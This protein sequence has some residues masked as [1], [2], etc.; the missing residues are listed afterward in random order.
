MSTQTL[1]NPYPGL[2]SFEPEDAHLFFG[3]DEQI[4]ELLRRLAQQRF[5]AVVGVSGSGKSSL[6]RAGVIPAL[7]R[8]YLSR[9][10]TRWRIAT[11]RPGNDPF[12]SLDQALRRDVQCEAALTRSSYA[13]IH[14][15]GTLAA[16]E[17]LLVVIDQFEEIFRYQEKLRGASEEIRREAAER[18]ADFVRLLLT[19]AQAA[20]APVYIVI[21]MRSDYLGDCAQFRDLPEALNG[22]QYLIPRMTREQRREAIEGP[23][24]P[25][26]IAPRLV[27][28]VLNDAGDEPVQLPILQHALMRTWERWRKRSKLGDPIDLPHYRAIGGFENALNRHA[29]IAF[30]TLRHDEETRRTIKVVFQRLTEKGANN[31]ETR[32]PTQLKELFAVVGASNEP[33]KQR[34]VVEAINH[35]RAPGAAFLISPDPELKADSVIDITHES[36]IRLW[37]RLRKWV[38]GEAESANVYRRLIES[39]QLYEK[40]KEDLLHGPAL[41]NTLAWKKEQQPT[42]AWAARY[43]GDFDS[44]MAF[45]DAS[46]REEAR[47]LEERERA[48]T[49]ELERAKER[50]RMLVFAVAGVGLAFLVGVLFYYQARQQRAMALSSRDQ[51]EKLIQFMTVD[52]RN[53]LKP[54]GHLDLMDRVNERVRNYYEKMGNAGTPGSQRW[55]AVALDNDGDALLARG[56]L[57]EALVNFQAGN[58]I[59]ERLT[60]QDPGNAGWQQDLC[61][62]YDSVGDVLSAQNKLPEALEAYQASKTIRE[63]LAKQDPSNFGWQWNLSVSYEKLG[64]VLEVQGKLEDALA[65]YQT[66]ET[67]RGRLAK[68][69]P[70]NANIQRDL[71]VSHGNLGAAL[72][73]QGKLDEALAS[74][75]ADKTII[76]RLAKQDPSNAEWQRDLSISFINVG[77]ILQAKGKL[78]EAVAAYEA[79]QTISER[80]VKLEPTNSDWQN[81]FAWVNNRL[82]SI[83]SGRSRK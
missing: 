44:A 31:R 78:D 66:N 34:V 64:R 6:V 50:A 43:G 82:A 28:T 65:A 57:A 1:S 80:L 52:L 13:L 29:E 15:T 83:E 69:D 73:A 38:D 79:S 12:A 5:V 72:Q 37:K 8:G 11:A 36:L 10:R 59:F 22:G 55:R 3:R 60:R 58:T 70:S 40:G 16:D 2:R 77:V 71:S 26:V 32:R 18:A 76:E 61:F 81:D 53:K 75:Q 47:R 27:Q 24:C 23:L 20:D 67:I 21:T 41:G 68:Q 35:F 51:A 56:K 54:L 48:H 42:A 62:S 74:Y 45:L 30:R 9:S 19:G 49:E 46:S 63:R 33:E 39:A 7:R 4:D 14:A 17:N 25:E